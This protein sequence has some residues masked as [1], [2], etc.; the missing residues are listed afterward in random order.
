MEPSF[1]AVLRVHRRAAG[2]TQ[3][4]LAERADLDF[5]YI[6]KLENDRLPPPA[7]DTVVTLCQIIGIPPEGLLALTG[8]I[9]SEIQHMVS[10]SSAAQEFLSEALRQGISEAEWRRLAGLLPHLK[11]EPDNR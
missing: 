4:E 7:A 11:D 3:R 6:S 2:L 1:G 8:K 9:P 5:T 10:S